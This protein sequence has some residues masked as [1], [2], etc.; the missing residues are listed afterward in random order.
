MFL[1]LWGM[2]VFFVVGS[3]GIAG[4]YASVM[5]LLRLMD[6]KVLRKCEERRAMAQ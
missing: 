5:A 2:V 3:F 4:C 1:S 6:C